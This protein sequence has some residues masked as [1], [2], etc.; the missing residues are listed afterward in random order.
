MCLDGVLG[1][2][3]RATGVSTVGVTRELDCLAGGKLEHL[4]ESSTNGQESFLA[5]LVAAALATS[6]IAITASGNA[7]TNSTSPDTDTEESFA[8]VD[9]DT[10]DFAILL[11]LESL[12]DG[13][14]HNLKPQAVNFDIA[15]V[16]VLV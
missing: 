10:H 9:D 14:H 8:H 2:G 11:I 4:L 7:L 3:S 6:N 15:L 13:R 12:T 1:L 5:L 16:L